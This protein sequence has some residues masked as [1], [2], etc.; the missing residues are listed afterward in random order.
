MGK[1]ID[2]DALHL[3]R[4]GVRIGGVEYLMAE[5]DFATAQ[6]FDEKMKA[7]QTA[8]GIGAISKATV[9]ALALLLPDVPRA[10]LEKLSDPKAAAILE[11]WRAVLAAETI[12]SAAD[13]K[14]AAS[15]PSSPG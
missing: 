10:V 14:A 1:I 5:Q 3:E 4:Q 6:K 12:Q 2:I 9:D 13:F 7:V 8:E 15:D 11:G